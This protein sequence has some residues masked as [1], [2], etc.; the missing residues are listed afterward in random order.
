MESSLASLT[1]CFEVAKYSPV[2]VLL[3]VGFDAAMGL[4]VIVLE[5]EVVANRVLNTVY[6]GK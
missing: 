1:S 5:V 2:V 4:T 6:K 3:V